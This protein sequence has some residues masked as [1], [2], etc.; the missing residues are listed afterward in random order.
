[1]CITIEK[2]QIVNT[3]VIHIFVLRKSVHDATNVKIEKLFILAD[4]HICIIGL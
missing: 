4:S 2:K 3:I 1:M